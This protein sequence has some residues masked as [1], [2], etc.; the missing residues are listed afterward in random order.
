MEMCEKLHYSESEEK[1]GIRESVFFFAV[2]LENRLRKHDAD[3]GKTGWHGCDVK[4]LLKRLKEEIQ[5][6]E[7]SGDPDEMLDVSAFAMMIQSNKP[8]D[9]AYSM[10]DLRGRGKDGS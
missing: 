8:L 9:Q 2:R 6:F 5:E 7:E 4:F 3:R 1:L 10:E